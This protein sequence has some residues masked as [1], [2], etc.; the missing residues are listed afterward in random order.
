MS[1]VV[2]RFVPLAVCD[3]HRDRSSP[4][5]RSQLREPA[6]QDTLPVLCPRGSEVQSSGRGPMSSRAQQSFL[7]VT[8]PGQTGREKCG[9]GLCSRS[10]FIQ[11]LSNWNALLQEAV[12][13]L[14]CVHVH[15]CVCVCVC[16]RL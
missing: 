6:H 1:H 13:V 10:T 7:D 4:L 14:M 8:V 9:R 16:V 2:S 5:G 11:C 12:D 15:F 3:H